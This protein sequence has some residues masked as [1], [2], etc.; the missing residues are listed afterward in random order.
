[1][2]VSFEVAPDDSDFAGIGIALGELMAAIQGLDPTHRHLLEQ[3]WRAERD[4]AAGGG[5]PALARIFD[6]LQ[7]LVLQVRSA[8]GET[9]G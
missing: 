2:S 4:G 6:S 5:Y 8:Q 1:M 9:D 3:A 7:A